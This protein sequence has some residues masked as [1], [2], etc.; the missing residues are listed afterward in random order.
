MTVRP[1]R[2]LASASA[3][4]G[5]GIGVAVKLAPRTPVAALV[6]LMT[7]IHTAPAQDSRPESK[8]RASLVVFAP[9]V[10]PEAGASIPVGRR[11]ALE[12][13]K[14][15]EDLWICGDARI[16][17]PL[18]AG[19]ARPTSPGAIELKAYPVI[20]K[21]EVAGPGRPDFASNI[22]FWR[23]FRHIK[24][25]NIAMTAPV[26]MEYRG[27]GGPEAEGG[28]VDGWSM[29]FLYREPSL[30]PTGDADDVRVVDS[31]PATYLSMGAV[32][33]YGVKDAMRI[34]ESLRQAL[35]ELP[36]LEA[37]GDVRVLH[38]NGPEVRDG[39]R[40]FEVQI[41]VRLRS[42]A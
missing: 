28:R 40:W 14:I 17:T 13:A 32:G 33:S 6:L 20:R 26:E 23:L 27:V 16:M 11:P 25:R 24:S 22:G 10:L 1:P 39:R 41:P 5:V 31:T 42:R 15:S 12:A 18:P 35:A 34:L 4:R 8:A 9:D 7:M 19:Y 38:Y 36:A 29:A 3:A 21:A 37:A 2:R 30:G